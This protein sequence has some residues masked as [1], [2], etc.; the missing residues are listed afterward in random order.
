MATAL[1]MYGKYEVRGVKDMNAEIVKI[2]KGVLTIGTNAF[3]NCENLTQIVIP[4]SVKEIRSHAFDGCKSL[5]HLE[6]PDSVEGI[7]FDAFARCTSLKEI[8]L[9]LSLKK[10][11]KGVF[12]GC[13]SL[14]KVTIKENLKYIDW[15]AFYG[16]TQIEEYVISDQNSKYCSENGIAYNKKKTI[17]YKIPANIQEK[18]F[19]VKDGVKKIQKE[20]F[21]YCKKIKQIVFPSSISEICEGA[22]RHCSLEEVTIPASVTEVG[23]YA[24]ADCVSLKKIAISG[25]VSIIPYSFASGCTS[26]EEVSLQ[27]GSRWIGQWAFSDCKSLKKIYIPASVMQLYKNSFNGCNSLEQIEVASGSKFFSS[28]DG[29]LYNKGMDW[30]IYPPAH[31]N[32]CFVVPST[33]FYL[34]DTFEHCHNLRELHFPTYASSFNRICVDCPNLTAIHMYS[35]NLENVSIWVNTFSDVN[36]KSCTLYV[37]Q[38]YAES[39]RKHPAFMAFEH[40]EEEEQQNEELPFR[41]MLQYSEDASVITGV[42]WPFTLYVYHAEIPEGIKEIGERVFKGCENLMSVSFPKTLEY[43]HAAAFWGCKQLKSLI[44]PEGLKEIG[45]S[46]FKYCSALESVSLPSTLS[47]I[48][49]KAFSQCKHLNTLVIPEGLKEIGGLAFED[50]SAL[51]SV[52][53]PSTLSVLNSKAFSGCSGLTSVTIPNSVTSIGGYVFSGCSGLTSVT[54]PNSVTSIGGH[55]FSGCSGLTSVTIPNSVTSIGGH[56]FSGCKHLKKLAL[57]E[58]LKAIGAGIIDG[59][60]ISHIHIPAS[61]EQIS[62]NAFFSDKLTEITVDKDNPYYNSRDGVLYSKDFTKLL[63]V[64]AEKPIPKFTIPAGVVSVSAEAFHNCKYIKTLVI[65][66]DIADFPIEIFTKSR[67]DDELL[68]EYPDESFTDYIPQLENIEVGPNNKLFKLV[69]G[70]L[71]SKDGKRLIRMCLNSQPEKYV[72]PE[73]VTKV[74]DGAFRGCDKIESFTIHEQVSSIGKNVFEGCTGIKELHVK[75]PVINLHRNVF[76]GIIREKCHLFTWENSL[77]FLFYREAFNHFII[78]TY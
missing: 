78:H 12:Y 60:T 43:I 39:Y 18:E 1:K 42:K 50:C 67:I 34:E 58:H 75:C 11:V 69:D 49:C 4:N 26:L 72:V 73:S 2:P 30:F 15:S 76:D 45:H 56:A 24:F 46:A 5:T 28:V 77:G 14:R 23:Q 38:G 55:A 64:P 35:R 41:D 7:Q 27:K 62:P 66:D 65:N 25:S 37:P 71:F 19:V 13:T 16:C 22:F 29:V 51:E 63:C 10:L 44:L 40:I 57:P 36:K 21:S 33:V 47:V 8:I 52:S 3:Y 54:I 20:A 6:I 31:K 53:L 74:E 68:C 59:T 70:V 32:D 17:L 48:N 9:P 61:T